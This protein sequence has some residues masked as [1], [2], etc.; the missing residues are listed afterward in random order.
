MSAGP[1]APEWLYALAGAASGEEDVCGS[2][3][4]GSV[5]A[6]GR[7]QRLWHLLAAR[8]AAAGPVG[9]EYGSTVDVGVTCAVSTGCVGPLCACGGRGWPTAAGT[10]ARTKGSFV[11]VH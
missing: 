1:R 7:A 9:V 5:G 6:A 10:R 2:E 11:R 4:E 3:A 8:G